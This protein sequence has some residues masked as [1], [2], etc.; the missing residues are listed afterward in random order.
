MCQSIRVVLSG[1]AVKASDAVGGVG[2][3]GRGGGVVNV[4]EQGAGGAVLVCC[5][6]SCCPALPRPAR[7][8]VLVRGPRHTV[9]VPH[10]RTETQ[11]SPGPFL[12]TVTFRQED[13][14]T[15][16]TQVTFVE[17]HIFFYLVGLY[18]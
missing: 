16:K 1:G 4:A 17:V 3:A 14:I 8:V 9:W 6:L 10:A 12:V 5:R 15:S 11:T 18:R 7:L 2:A 13:E